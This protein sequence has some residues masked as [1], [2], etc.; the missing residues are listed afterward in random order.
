MPKE[1]FYD[2]FIEPGLRYSPELVEWFRNMEIPN[3]VT[4]TIANEITVDPN[5]GVMLP[6]HSA[7]MRNLG[8]TLTEICWLDDLANACH[9]DNR[10][11]F[12]YTAAPLKVVEGCVAPVNP[13]AIR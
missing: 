9:A 12:L 4:D 7:L 1:E 8:V 13:I 11:T 2:G 5:S 6:L 10:W 3:L